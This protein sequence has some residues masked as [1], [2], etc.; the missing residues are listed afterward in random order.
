VNEKNDL[1]VLSS[2]LVDREHADIRLGIISYQV[3]IIAGC[4]VLLVK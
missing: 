4:P 1:M 3:A 2:H